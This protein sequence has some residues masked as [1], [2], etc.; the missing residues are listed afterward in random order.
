MVS[1]VNNDGLVKIITPENPPIIMSNSKPDSFSPANKK[2]I[3]EVTNA[4]VIMIDTAMLTGI[5]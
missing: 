3:N 1:G 4:V 5:N 2:A